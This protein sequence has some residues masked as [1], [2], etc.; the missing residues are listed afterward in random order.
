MED[1][2]GEGDGDGWWDDAVAEDAAAPVAAAD[3]VDNDGGE[4][5]GD[6][7]G[8]WDDAVAEDATAPAEDAPAAAVDGVTRRTILQQADC[9]ECINCLDKPKF[10]GPFKKKQACKLKLE[11]LKALAAGGALS[12]EVEEEAEADE[13]EEEAEEE[14]EE[15]AIVPAKRS[16]PRRGRS[17]ESVGALSAEPRT[18]GSKRGRRQVTGAADAGEAD[19]WW[20]EAVAEDADAEVAVA[21]VA[22]AEAAVAL[23][24]VKLGGCTYFVGDTVLVKAE[25]G[26]AKGGAHTLSHTHWVLRLDAMWRAAGRAG[27]FV[28]GRW[29][30]YPEETDSG[31]LAGHQTHEIF[32]SEHSSGPMPVDDTGPLD[33]PAAVLAWPDYQLWLDG[34]SNDLDDVATFACRASYHRGSGEFRPLTGACSLAEASMPTE[35]DAEGDGGGDGGDG[36]GG[37]GGGGRRP[38]SRF[39]EAAARLAPSAAP[40][41]LPCRERNLEDVSTA[42][43]CAV[44][45]GGL[46]AALYL[47]GT[48]GTGKTATV[49]QALRHLAAEE[50]LPRFRVIEINGMK[51]SS[52]HQVYSILWEALTGENAP[53]ARAA[54]LLE[55][56]LPSAGY[57]PTAASTSGAAA[58]APR[59]A[60]SEPTILV[61]DE[62]DYLVTRKQEVIYNLFEWAAQARG[63]IV[64]AISNTMDLPER[65]MPRV[66]SRLGIR[67]VN[68]LPYT[69]AELSVILTERLAACQGAFGRD[70]I[71][72]AARKVA[73]VSGDVRR[74]LETCRLAAQLAEVERAEEV[75]FGHIDEAAKQLRASPKT[76]AMSD[77]PRFEQLLL[78]AAVLEHAATGR[79]VLFRH[80]LAAR[81][82]ALCQTYGGEGGG[83][84]LSRPEHD[85]I[86]A[87]LVCSRL[88]AP[89]AD[90]A[91]ALQGALTL[92]VQAEDVVYCC[93]EAAPGCAALARIAMPA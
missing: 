8:W 86:V 68:F 54:R 27:T 58:A 37:G 52:P 3:A 78:V 65:L 32:L 7:D 55:A 19:D 43:R 31:L 63:L 29:Y 60:L 74:A 36:D 47:S 35:L 91:H 30:Y 90:S 50:G 70:G 80:E 39:A 16:A 17:S 20:A 22:V 42:L 77:A 28:E 33:G 46:G 12:G 57:H 85:E 34:A 49:R 81:H 87:R 88:L 1:E 4:G 89:A 56:R 64:V 83:V 25:D 41:R 62:L 18:I 76:R 51:L 45:E 38:F 2:E 67:R 71:E 53:P 9:G 40:A 48:P 5:G 59:R 10:G 92:L 23:D 6:G 61:V 79:A 24:E 69:H 73:S 11:N 75:G 14:E 82:V 93:T 21:K 13:E 72:L 26:A 84:R 66:A 15:A 44:R